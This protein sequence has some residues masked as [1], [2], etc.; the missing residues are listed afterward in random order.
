MKIIID[1]KKANILNVIEELCED[2]NNILDITKPCN[3][4][5]TR[6]KSVVFL[7][8]IKITIDTNSLDSYRL[9]ELNQTIKR[10]LTAYDITYTK[11]KETLNDTVYKKIVI[12]DKTIYK[13]KF[14]YNKSVK[15]I[16]F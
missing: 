1:E 10:L 9:H 6:E 2:M 8:K 7:K 13:M 15:N 3:L 4:L 14:G 12:T 11:T 16:K 5:H